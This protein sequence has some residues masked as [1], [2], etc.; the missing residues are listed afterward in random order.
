[1]VA[2]GTRIPPRNPVHARHP[3]SRLPWFAHF[4]GL[5]GRS[6][7]CTDV[8][9]FPANGAFYFQAF[10]GLA[11]WRALDLCQVQCIPAKLVGLGLGD[12]DHVGV[13]PTLPSCAAAAP[14]ASRRMIS[15][16]QPRPREYDPRPRNRLSRVKPDWRE[17]VADKQIGD[18]QATP[19]QLQLQ[20]GTCASE[21]LHAAGLTSQ[22]SSRLTSRGSRLLTRGGRT[23]FTT[24][25]RGCCAWP[26]SASRCPPPSAGADRSSGSAC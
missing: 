15:N 25:S 9:G 26:A 19:R 1:M 21:G 2:V 16:K 22:R 5:S 3:I 8:T 13:E 6:V 7:P 10:S 24:R 23:C 14:P 12:V 17:S 11:T 20:S 4:Y 18:A